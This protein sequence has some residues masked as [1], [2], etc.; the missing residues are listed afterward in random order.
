MN[1][2]GTRFIAGGTGTAYYV[3]HKESGTWNSTGIN[4]V[5]SGDQL[6]Y[7]SRWEYSCRGYSLDTRVI[8]DALPCINIVEVRGVRLLI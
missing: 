2:E 8:W 3:Y 1:K 7:E 5:R 6:W 4:K